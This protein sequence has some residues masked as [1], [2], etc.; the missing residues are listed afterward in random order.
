[1]NI[2]EE[3]KLKMR[4]LRQCWRDFDGRRD[5]RR[6]V[7][8]IWAC[9]RGCTNAPKRRCEQL[10]L[11]GFKRDSCKPKKYCV[12]IIRH[13]NMQLQFTEGTN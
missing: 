13:D 6:K 10:I 9:I 2:L 1:M 8:M 5:P 7:A 4:Y 11:D 12:D 3:I